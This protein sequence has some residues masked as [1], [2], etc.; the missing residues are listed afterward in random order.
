MVWNI[1]FIIFIAW[2]FDKMS[3]CKV[4]MILDGGSYKITYTKNGKQ[5]KITIGS[6]NSITVMAA[7]KI[8][9]EVQQLLEADLN[10]SHLK[11]MYIL[12]KDT[13]RCG[14]KGSI[15]RYQS[16]SIEIAVR[17][18]FPNQ[19]NDFVSMDSFS[20]IKIEQ[21]P[22]EIL[23]I[24][25][26]GAGK[27]R[28]IISAILSREALRNFVPAL[29]SLKETT[30]C[31]IIYHINSKESE[32][33][34]GCDYKVLVVLKNE[35]EVINSIKALVTEAVEEYIVTIKENAKN[36]SDM[37]I[38]CRK[39]KEAVAKRLEINY[40]KTFGLGVRNINID[41][42][43]EIEGLTKRALMGYYG[44]SK[45]IEKLE[46]DDSDF[47]LE[48]LRKD[49]EK[50]ELNISNEEV[51]KMLSV[52][53]MEDIIQ[54][55]Y[56]ELKK[57]LQAY[58]VE[59]TA[60]ATVGS[61][62]YH[63]GKSEEEHTLMYL[64]HVFGNKSKQRKGDFYTIEPLVKR[65]EF[66]I[67][68][69][70]LAFDREIILSDSVG[71][72]QGQKDASRINEIVF[73]RVHESIQIRKPDIV[74]YH[75]KLNN[76]DDYMLD[77]VKLLNSHAY[78]KVTYIVAG[79]LDDALNTYLKD[80]YIEKD[81]VTNEIFVDF[82]EEMKDIYIDSDVTLKTIVE[83]RY[84]VCDKTNGISESYDFAREYS[85]MSILNKVIEGRLR[86]DDSTSL[87]TDIDFMEIVQSNNVSGNV[88]QKYL[89]N[90]STMI[91]LNYH[92]MRWNTLQKAIEEL[93][94]DGYG[95]DVLYPAFNVKNAIA[96]ELNRDEIKLEFLN[97]FGSDEEEMKRRYLLEVA[98]IA[99]TVLVTEYRS[100]MRQL[101]DMRYDQKLRTNLN[102]SMTDDRKYNLQKLYNTCL[103]KEGIKGAYAMKIVFHIAWV[104]TLEFFE[105]RARF[106][107]GIKL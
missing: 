64:S 15:I 73:N 14:Y 28:F 67:V 36:I 69:N 42:A 8:C 35:E 9:Q 16:E 50:D 107:L 22:L 81:D 44:N 82:I 24:G 77:V 3:E 41:L 54:V 13:N 27:T 40:D 101:L 55:I 96:E 21:K 65:A 80:N 91:P 38:L 95:F 29:T 26:T 66:F 105:R 43:I 1:L 30:A 56:S 88:Y 17:I 61:T 47:I 52:C 58:N 25:C 78:G 100:F 93:R 53:S 106:S 12:N 102:I 71:I 103:E 49:F 70:K 46:K 89:D 19:Y 63:C 60:N 90:I 57:N 68:S 6:E 4:N 7:R 94:W 11:K 23:N 74:L 51:V 45:S 83:D 48:Q 32:I 20:Q 79:R 2:R 37:G 5:S 72:N 98:D 62:I 92:Q 31:S 99:Q 86:V 75:T 84:L 33:G 39:C 104:R 87:F 34:I 10:I 18:L 85:C 97:K 59:Y 76:K